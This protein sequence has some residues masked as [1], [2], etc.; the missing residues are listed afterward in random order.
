MSD[1]LRVI[2]DQIDKGDDVLVVNH[3]PRPRRARVQS[4]LR[5][6]IAIRYDDDP[7]LV[8]RVMMKDIQRVESEAPPDP[9]HKS[10]PPP[11]K[12]APPPK[13][14]P[15]AKPE[16]QPKDDV[17]A[18]LDMGREMIEKLKA[19][20]DSLITEQGNLRLDAAEMIRESDECGRRANE[21]EKRV[22]AIEAIAGVK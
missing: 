19:E 21:L 9:P 4:V 22:E 5:G 3:G 12:P 18:W 20:I 11:P 8:R 1:R 6:A 17:Q 16:Q 10:T 13:L 14:E 15:E 7:K 2:R